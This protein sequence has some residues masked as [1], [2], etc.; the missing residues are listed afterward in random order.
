MKLCCVN[1]NYILNSVM[2]TET[3]KSI[4]CTCIEQLNT[5]EPFIMEIAHE[6]LKKDTGKLVV[7][8]GAH[9][10]NYSYLAYDLGYHVVA[11][12]CRSDW[13][14][15]LSD[16]ILKNGCGDKI[17]VLHERVGSSISLSDIL[18]QTSFNS[19]YLLKMDIEG[20]EPDVINSSRDMITNRLVSHILCEIS[21]KYSDSYGNMSQFICDNGYD[22]YD[23]GLGDDLRPFNKDTC[24][25]ETLQKITTNLSSYIQ[26][27]PHG[28]TNFYFVK[29]DT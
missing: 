28:Q 26:N 8:V 18:R 15:A 24:H 11:C 14:D 6:I 25:F 23:I 20:A 19:I 21:P 29:K 3:Q 22:V 4:V 27:I 1:R 13:V 17:S 9:V 10:G 12:E 16:S 5:W 2:E 7:D